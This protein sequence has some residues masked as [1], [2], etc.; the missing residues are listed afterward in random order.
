MSIIVGTESG[1]RDVL[2]VHG[3]NIL[4]GIMIIITASKRIVSM[5]STWIQQLRDE[6]FLIGRRLHNV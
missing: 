2:M 6:Q 5:V 1:V 3:V 4:L